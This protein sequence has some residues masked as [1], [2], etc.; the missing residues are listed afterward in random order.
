LQFNEVDIFQVFIVI[1]G[2]AVGRGNI[3]VQQVVDPFPRHRCD[4]R[5]VHGVLVTLVP[6]FCYRNSAAL[7]EQEDAG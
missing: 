3:Y 4:M 5:D 1:E 2:R 6:V 7:E